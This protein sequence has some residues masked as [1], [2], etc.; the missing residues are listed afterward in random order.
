MSEAG[1]T[2]LE[3][4]KEA[5]VVSGIE[6]RTALLL[7]VLAVAVPFGMGLWFLSGRN[8]SLQEFLVVIVLALLAFW[9]I[10]TVGIILLWGLGRL[11]LPEQLVHYLGV[12]TVGEIAGIV[13]LVVRNVL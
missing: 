9:S 12:A 3:P 7:V 10:A 6:L 5:R 11:V 2:P 13:V 1:P 4:I 8:P